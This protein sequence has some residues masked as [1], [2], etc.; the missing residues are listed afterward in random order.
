M[1]RTVRGP[2]PDCDTFMA[3][4]RSASAKELNTFCTPSCTTTD[5]HSSLRFTYNVVM[6]LV[7]IVC[8]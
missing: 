1:K 2:P 8:E 6:S 4:L 7:S 3:S 5:T